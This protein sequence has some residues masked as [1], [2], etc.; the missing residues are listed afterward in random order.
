[1]LNLTESTKNLFVEL[2]KDAPNWSGTPL[3][4]GTKSQQG[5]L[6]DLKK[7][8]LITTQQDSDNSRC[9]WVY[10]TDAG[11]KYAIDLLG[12]HGDYFD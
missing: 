1:M 6:T 10:F 4:Q 9:F 3:F 8:G 11:K 2:V 5:N 12:V 7:N